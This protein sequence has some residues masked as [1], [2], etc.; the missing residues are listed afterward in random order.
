MI[1][2]PLETEGFATLFFSAGLREKR[3][4][5]RRP[6]PLADA[7]KETEKEDVIG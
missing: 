6:Y 3:I 5:R 7:V 4:S 1:H 2:G